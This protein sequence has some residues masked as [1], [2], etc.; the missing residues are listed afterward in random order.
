[1][2]GLWNVIDSTT[3]GPA[4]LEHEGMLGS[5]PYRGHLRPKRCRSITNQHFD[6]RSQGYFLDWPTRWHDAEQRHSWRA[7]WAA[8]FVRAWRKTVDICADQAQFPVLT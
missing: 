7:P 1:E 2:D 3:G 4:M 5:N 8:T 6:A